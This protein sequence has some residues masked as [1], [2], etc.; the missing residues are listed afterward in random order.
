M[1]HRGA[2]P[3]DDVPRLE[4]GS[5]R[6]D[7]VGQPD[8]RVEWRAEDRATG[9]G[10]DDRAIAVEGRP[11]EAQVDRADLVGGRAEDEGPEDALS[12][13]VSNRPIFQSRIRLSTISS[14]GRTKSTAAIASG[15]VTPGRAATFR[16]KATSGSIRGWRKPVMGDRHVLEVEEVV[17]QMPEVGVLPRGGSAS[18]RWSGPP[19][20]P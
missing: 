16:T 13:T 18:P 8:Q 1:A 3:R 6:A 15:T 11:G 5:H 17:E 19:C 7:G 9:P 20:V 14:A 12:A 10:A 2:G 4:G